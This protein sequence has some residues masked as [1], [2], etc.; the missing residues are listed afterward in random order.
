[1][2]L[3]IS[4]KNYLCQFDFMRYSLSF[5]IFIILKLC[6]LCSPPSKNPPPPLRFI[7]KSL[8]D[9]LGGFCIPSSH[10]RRSQ[11]PK[12]LRKIKKPSDLIASIHSC[13]RDRRNVGQKAYSYVQYH[14]VQN[15]KIDF[16][17][18]LSYLH[19]NYKFGV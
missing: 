3:K 6:F 17:K 4:M 19:L 9:A 10:H 11:N 13:T 16:L 1:M 12:T 5:L 15:D 14:C 2:K 18:E 8:E 7:L